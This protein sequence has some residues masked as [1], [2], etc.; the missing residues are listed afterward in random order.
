MALYMAVN[1]DAYPPTLQHLIELGQPEDIFVCPSAEDEEPFGYFY[2]ST[3]SKAPG[4]T[5]IACDF[6]GNHDDYRNVLRAD[7]SSMNV[8]EEEFEALLQFPWNAAFAA[9]LR[10]AEKLR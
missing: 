9:A 10:E 6:E 1:D 7:W 8:D 3:D 5:L 2:L 4:Q